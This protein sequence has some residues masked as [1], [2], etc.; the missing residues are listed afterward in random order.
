[1][2]RGAYVESFRLFRNDLDGYEK[3]F[4]DNLN[5]LLAIRNGH[6]RGWAEGKQGAEFTSLEVYPRP[7]REIP[8]WYASSG[9]PQSAVHAGNLGL[10]IALAV[11]SGQSQNYV[12][13]VERYRQASS[14]L[15]TRSFNPRIGIN[16]HGFVGLNEAKATEDFFPYYASAM[17]R[18]RRGRELEEF[19]LSEFDYNARREN[20]LVF[21]TPSQVVDKILYHQELFGHQRFLMHMSA[22]N[23]PHNSIMRSIELL[24]TV[25]AP[26]VRSALRDKA[27][28]PAEI[29]LEHAV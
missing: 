6:I 25:V 17:N 9:S 12:S 23:V 14:S 20:S 10:P 4:T 28:A 21:G 3:Q 8:I 1:V 5:S 2:G 24:G 7:E 29:R 13:F 11:H 27:G 22:G 16:C 19:T 18:I 26:A 15:N